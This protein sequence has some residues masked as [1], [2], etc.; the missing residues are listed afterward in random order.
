MSVAQNRYLHLS[1]KF[2]GWAQLQ[3]FWNCPQMGDPPQTE[4]FIDKIRQVIIDD[5]VLTV[6]TNPFVLFWNFF[7]RWQHFSFCQDVKFREPNFGHSCQASNLT[8]SFCDINLRACWNPQFCW[9]K[10]SIFWSWRNRAPSHGR[11]WVP[12][13]SMP[14]SKGGGVVIGACPCVEM[15]RAMAASLVDGMGSYI[16]YSKPYGGFLKWHPSH[17][18]HGWPSFKSI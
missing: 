8:F 18:S 5:G 12:R 11:I 9:W 14:I 13:S 15:P 2:K 17:P 16:F 7:R 3:F 6:E 1:N 10:T 4:A